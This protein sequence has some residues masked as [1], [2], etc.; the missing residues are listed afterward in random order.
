MT[1][2]ILELA[3]EFV[4]YLGSSDRRG[5]PDGDGRHIMQGLQEYSRN[6]PLQRA[7]LAGA[8]TGTLLHGPG[9]LF[10]TPGL[11]T[12]IIST[13]V[14]SKGLGQLL[15]AFP[16][17][18]THPWFGFLTGVSD[19]QGNEPTYPCDDAPT[20]YIKSGTLTARFG[21]VQRDTN[22]IRLP[23][24]I[25]RTNRGDMTDLM[26]IGQ[27]LNDDGRGILYP[28]DIPDGQTM[29]DMV[30]AAEQVQ[31]GIRMERKLAKLLWTGDA[32]VKTL[33]GYAE[34]PGL[35]NQLVT[36]QKDAE[37]NAN[38]PSADATI[39]DA[40]YNSIGSSTY[41]LVA[42]MEEGEDFVFNLAM[43]TGMDPFT[44]VIAMRP[45]AWRVVS[46]IWPIAYNTQPDMQLIAGG[47]ARVIIDARTNV[48]ERDAMRQGLYLD[49]NGRRYP[50]VI[51]NSI[52]EENHATNAGLG[53]GEYASSINFIP[54]T[55]AGMPVTYWQHKDYT[56]IGSQMGNIPSGL[57][58]WYTD[59]G[60]FLW[61]MDG[62]FTCFKLKLETEPRVV[63]RT[64]HLSFRVT[65]LKYT[66]THA[67]LRD[68]DPASEYW[69]N[70]GPSLRS[71][72]GPQQFAAWL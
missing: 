63:A 16:S 29:L 72:A 58:T 18:D 5:R 31:T 3:K 33:G 59:G 26:L 11:D 35:E 40:A 64:P 53:V 70:G 23:D 57:E 68:P 21:V 46:S 55:A 10:N 51:D 48:Q 22:T 71:V 30:V 1:D 9:G 49:L 12:A 39:I 56:L 19:D 52:P 60:R 69:V 47:T 14:Q 24:V 13:H 37:T 28:A 38:L 7:A 45:Q 2:P 25:E 67:P 43:D 27:L 15:P 61:S 36:G 54:L 32:T 66:R 17:V 42:A 62:K 41:D 34:Y 50:V 6:Q 4:S 8:H 65:R 20:G 44:A